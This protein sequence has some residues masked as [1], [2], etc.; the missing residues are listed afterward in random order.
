[1][2][3]PS[4]RVIDWINRRGFNDAEEVKEYVRQH[5]G[6]SLTMDSSIDFVFGSGKQE[7]ELPIPQSTGKTPLEQIR[8]GETRPEEIQESPQLAPYEGTLPENVKESISAPV[9]PDIKRKSLF[10][11]F[12][13]WLGS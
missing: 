1:M 12:I 4:Q 9:S 6:A 10:R 13:D 11:R 8:E 3:P 7:E 5:G 2:S